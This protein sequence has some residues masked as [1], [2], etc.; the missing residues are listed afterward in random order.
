ME[1]PM[2][3]LSVFR[4]R[5]FTCSTIIIMIVYAG[6]ISSEL[7]IPMYLQNARGYSALDA[8]LALMPGAIIMG[9]MN[10]ITGMLF[11]KIG[12]RL[13]SLIGLVCFTIGTL[14]LHS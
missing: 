2:L 14:L 6:M 11:D 10:P 1:E 13:L 9:V 7:I 8:G 5:V 4:S 12:S 3:N